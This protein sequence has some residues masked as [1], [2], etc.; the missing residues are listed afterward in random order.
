MDIKKLKKARTEIDKI[1]QKLFLL[2]V[3]RTRIVKHMLGLKKYKKQI[4][5]KKRINEILKKI[6]IKTI[7]NKI[8]PKIPTRIWKS[9]IWSYVEY[10]RKNFKKT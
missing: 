2:I 1:D 4:V 3:K 10:Q 5:D 8:D 6:K 9:M 7:Q